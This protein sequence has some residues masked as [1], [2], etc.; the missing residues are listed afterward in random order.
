MVTIYALI[1]RAN[2]MAYVGSTKGKPAKRMREHRCLLN[3]GIHKVPRMQSDWQSYGS[4]QFMIVNLESLNNSTLEIRRFSELKWM[5]KFAEKDKLYNEHRISMRP[6]D[7][8]IRKG[9]ANS[10]TSIG[11]RWSPETNEKR[12]MAQL[13]KPKGHGAKISAT[14]KMLGQRPSLEAARQGGIAA[15]KKRYGTGDEIV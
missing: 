5:D 12:R 1:C 11:N 9:V 2:D 14:K 10:R 8:A 3:Q 4:D 13:G 7:E 15:C 6:T